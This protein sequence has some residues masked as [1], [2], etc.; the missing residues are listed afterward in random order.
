MEKNKSNIGHNSNLL[1]EDAIKNDV[2]EILVDACRSSKRASDMALHMWIK[3]SDLFKK[4]SPLT[5]EQINWNL[6]VDKYNDWVMQQDP[7]PATN[8]KKLRK[9]YKPRK[10]TSDEAYDLYKQ[11]DREFN[12]LFDL[13]GDTIALFRGSENSQLEE[14]ATE[15]DCEKN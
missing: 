7:N 9:K 12:E 4:E 8:K 5:K 14:I 11:M 2:R 3:F 1:I 13:S 10:L 6:N 15:V